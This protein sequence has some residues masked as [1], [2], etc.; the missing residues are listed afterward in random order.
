MNFISKKFLT[1]AD[2]ALKTVE[3]I[4]GEEALNN[5]KKSSID[6]LSSGYLENENGNFNKFIPFNA[7]L[8][9]APITSFSEIEINNQKQL[10]ISG[11]SLKVNTYHGGYKSL[12]GFLMTSKNDIK[13]VSELGLK[14]FNNQVKET[15]VIKMF[16]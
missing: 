2:F 13:P 4:F 6:I 11:N 8:Q 12:K 10:L 7:K 14:P 15:A 1:H 5:A 3:T 16:Y 9:V